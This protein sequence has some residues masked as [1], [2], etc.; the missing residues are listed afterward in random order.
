ML[1]LGT[2]LF[3]YTNLWMEF[4]FNGQRIRLHGLTQPQFTQIRA[5]T[6][7][8][9]DTDLM[10]MYQLTVEPIQSQHD[11]QFGSDAPNCIATQ[12]RSLLQEFQ[13]IF[14]APT[15]LPPVKDHDHHIPLLPRVPPVNVK[16]YRYPY[17]QK[18]EIE[19]LV[20]EMLADGVIRPSTS[21]FSS[22]VLLV[23]KKD[24]T[25]RF[26]VDYRAL[27]AVTV[28]DRF[29]IP[30]VAELLDEIAGA[31]IFSKPTRC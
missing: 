19:K 30:T 28:K 20:G 5:A 23:K 24:G 22:P 2:V 27:N 17:F 6:L 18:A 25:W 10:Q 1:K 7:T 4:D 31:R 3:Y 14:A 8:K 21:P 11:Q 26:C 29:P 12:L 15:G 13:D 9:S 16:P